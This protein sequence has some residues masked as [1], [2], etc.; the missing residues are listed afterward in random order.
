MPEVIVSN[1]F[2]RFHLRL[3]AAEAH[4]RSALTALVTGV[5]PGVGLVR[6]LRATGLSR[7]AATH[8]LP[9]RCVALPDV[10][11]RALWTG[12]AFAQF[13]NLMRSCSRAVADYLDLLAR[14]LYA[15]RA[16]RVFEPFPYG[17]RL[18]NL[19]GRLLER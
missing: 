10:L 16:M 18:F 12:E 6:L 13:A 2:G 1:G 11:V 9:A 14:G 17:D 19:Y 7:I 3:A 5:Y 15:R 4:R 8:R